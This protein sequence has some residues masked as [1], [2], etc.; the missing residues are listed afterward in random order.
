MQLLKKSLQIL[1]TTDTLIVKYQSDA[2]PV[3]EVMPDFHALP[4]H[5]KRLVK[6]RY[7]S[8]EEGYYMINLTTRSFRFVY[9]KAYGLA[10]LLDPRFVCKGL[11][12]AN[13]S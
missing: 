4:T 1:A 10:Y 12:T 8:A 3:S 13:R 11:D 2:I 6:D 9:G 5:F 7:V